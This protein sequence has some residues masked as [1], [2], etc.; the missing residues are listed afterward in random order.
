MARRRDAAAFDAR[1]RDY[2]QGW[3]GA[4]HRD[5]AD[6]TLGIAL[7]LAPDARRLLDIGCGTGY[8]LRQA[9]LRLG[10]A[11]EL[12]GIDPAAAMIEAAQ[13][14]ADDDRLVF[15]RGIA[16]KLPFPDGSFDL[17]LATTSFDHWSDQ[18]T[19]LSES[20]RILTPGGYFVVVDLL[21]SWLLP[22]VLTVRRGHARTPRR[23]RALLGDAGLL[24]VRQQRL[25]IIVQALSARKPE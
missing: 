11:A 20:A 24:P 12:V 25:N 21:S 19:G 10:G 22:T 15:R 8:M 7:A 3:L 17:V 18:P 9:A 23:L 13:T 4:F 1:A 16:E 6:E 2:E 14:V 5:L